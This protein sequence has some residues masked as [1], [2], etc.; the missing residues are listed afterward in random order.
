M[1]NP[2]DLLKSRMEPEQM[3]QEAKWKKKKKKGSKATNGNDVTVQQSE[4]RVRS[5]VEPEVAHQ[6]SKV[7]AI[8]H[9]E[10]NTRADDDNMSLEEACPQLLRVATKDGRISV[11]NDWILQVSS[12]TILFSSVK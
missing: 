6:A 11:W 12:S 10:I 8:N 9:V 7:A 5:T 2:Y 1:S 4:S 3:I